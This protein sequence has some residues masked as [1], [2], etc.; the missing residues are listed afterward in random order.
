MCET[1][2]ELDKKIEHYR[3]IRNRALDDL[4][5]AGLTRLI[6]EAEAKKAALHPEQK[7]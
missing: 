3:V 6:E 5:I 7:K 4:I 2:K 1:C